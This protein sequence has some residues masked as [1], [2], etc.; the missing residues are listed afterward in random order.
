[1]E[2]GNGWILFDGCGQ[3]YLWIRLLDNG[4]I[5]CSNSQCGKNENVK[6]DKKH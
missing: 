2:K 6:I 4:G 5:T 3:Q 1:M